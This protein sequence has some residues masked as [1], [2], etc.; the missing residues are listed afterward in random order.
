M[1]SP[2]GLVKLAQL[3]TEL[4]S[5]L[6]VAPTGDDRAVTD[7]VLYD[8]TDRTPIKQGDLVLGVGLPADPI[9]NHVIHEIADSR[10]AG[11]VLKVD[12]DLPRG[13]SDTARQRDLPILGLRHGVSWVEIAVLVRSVLAQAGSGERLEPLSGLPAG[14][15]FAVAVAVANL[16][17]API[18]IEDVQ[19]RVIAYS[20]RQEQADQARVDSILVRH[21]PDSILRKLR[22]EGI[23]RKLARSSSPVYFQP[24]GGLLRVAV[25]IRAGDEFIGSMWAAV[26]ARLPADKERKFVEAAPE[27]AIHML[28]HRVNDDLSRRTQMDLVTAV[29]DGRHDATE[30]AERLGMPNEGFRVMAAWM[31][32]K[33]GDSDM[34]ALRLRLWDFLALH[35]SSLDSPVLTSLIGSIV[36]AL[37]PAR[38]RQADE[39]KAALALAN[40]AVTSAALVMPGRYSIGIGSCVT[41]IQDIP[42]S[43]RE[44]ELALRV[45]RSRP[46]ARRRV[47]EFSDLRTQALLVQLADVKDLEGDPSDARMKALAEIDAKRDTQYIA[48]LE[49]YLEAFGDVKKAG[50]RLGV[51]PNT[52]RYRIRRLQQLAS[53]HLDDPDDRLSMMLELRLSRLHKEN[54]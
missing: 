45:L 26:R 34:E 8:P 49:A 41:Q 7:V 52:L 30:A 39:R 10:C 37:V 2:A 16:I 47:A 43:R 19:S 18:T 46:E 42:R 29:L 13:L 11:L 24:P 40:K 12:H 53:V 27:V 14:D 15:L 36:F 31:D 54:R 51:H 9:L 6:I 17:E 35:L 38:T 21:V 48:S 28:R 5:Y 22:E 44:A 50:Q 20:D 1:A 32:P 23:F 3:I 25:G 4:R 33:V